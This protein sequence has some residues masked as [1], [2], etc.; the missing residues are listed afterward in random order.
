MITRKIRNRRGIRNTLENRINRNIRNNSSLRN[1]N[2]V[3]NSSFLNERNA[4]LEGRLQNKYATEGL[5]KSF[6]SYATILGF[7]GF[8]HIDVA[9]SMYEKQARKYLLKGKNIIIEGID[10]YGTILVNY[11]SKKDELLYYDVEGESDNRKEV[12]IDLD[13]ET[14]ID[15]EELINFE[16]DY[17][18]NLYDDENYPYIIDKLFYMLLTALWR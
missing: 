7:G 1:R 2:K 16:Y 5:K 11:D 4:Y 3:F 8:T 10:R 9:Y 13:S 18:H 12:K 14:Y 6:Q 17:D 15:E